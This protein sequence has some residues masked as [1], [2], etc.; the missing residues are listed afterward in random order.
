MAMLVCSEFELAQQKT[1]KFGT[2]NCLLSLYGNIRVSS[3][4]LGFLPFQI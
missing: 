4:I 1:R 2:D 3:F